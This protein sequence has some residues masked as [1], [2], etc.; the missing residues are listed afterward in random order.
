MFETAS[1]SPSSALNRIEL[2]DEEIEYAAVL[3]LM[4]E[5]MVGKGIDGG[6]LDDWRVLY[7]L[8]ILLE[9]YGCESGLA[10]YKAVVEIQARE[11]T[12]NPLISLILAANLDDPT[13]CTRSLERGEEWVWNEGTLKQMGVTKKSGVSGKSW[14]D[15]DYEG[16]GM[17]DVSMPL[18]MLQR[19]P[20]F[21]LSILLQT[22]TK[23]SEGK[24]GLVI[25]YEVWAP[26]FESKMTACKSRRPRIP[27]VVLIFSHCEPIACQNA[28]GGE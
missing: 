26:A 6:D 7:D 3:R 11:E 14:F 20:I 22:Y 21:Y 8:R 25:D 1:T 19:I 27:L 2:F 16:K 18:D 15:D 23:R 4:F 24:F 5:I 28:S 13:S 10:L 12:A 17:V 9:K